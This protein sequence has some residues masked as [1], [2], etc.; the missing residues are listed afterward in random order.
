[1]KS[2]NPY[3]TKDYDILKKLEQHN[4]L[5]K[6]GDSKII[7]FTYPKIKGKNIYF[8]ILKGWTNKTLDVCMKVKRDK[9][10]FCIFMISQE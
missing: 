6:Q 1:M 9:L 4:N 3:K 5:N 10:T 2:T 7:F 8:G